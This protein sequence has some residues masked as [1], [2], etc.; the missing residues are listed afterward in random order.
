MIY[1]TPSR[2]APIDQGDIFDG[3]PLLHLAAFNAADVMSGDLRSLDINSNFCRIIVLT[4]T[5][6]LA[7]RKT[8]VA[9]AGRL[10][11]AA[12]LVQQGIV[13][14]EEVRGPIRANRVYGW[15]FLPKNDQQSL[16]ESIVDF[17]QLHTVRLDLLAVLC[18]GG[19]RLCRLASLYREH[20]AQHFATTYSRIGLPAPYET[21]SGS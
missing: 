4:Q 7:N 3:C 21:L 15:Y 6:D 2:E 10:H 16:P 5:C 20:L 14:A 11:D 1:D 9:I 8:T 19:K 12:K 18:Q 17:R 13:K